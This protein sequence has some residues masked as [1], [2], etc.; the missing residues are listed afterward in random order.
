LWSLGGGGGGI[1]S[2]VMIG[3]ARWTQGGRKIDPFVAT[4]WTKGGGG[5]GGGSMGHWL[6]PEEG[7]E[8]IPPQPS[9]WGCTGDSGTLT[10]LGWG[11]KITLGGTWG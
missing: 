5:G 2:F 3:N 11:F 1:D 7:L 4:I 10:I 6:T 9:L 8:G